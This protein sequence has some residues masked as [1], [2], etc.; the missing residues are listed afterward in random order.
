MHLN[1]TSAI[2]EISQFKKEPS[3][4]IRK[5]SYKQKNTCSNLK[6]YAGKGWQEY[7]LYGIIQKVIIK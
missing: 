3:N 4:Y 7:L 1:Q 5:P 2:C 6:Q